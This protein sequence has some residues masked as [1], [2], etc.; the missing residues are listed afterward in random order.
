MCWE[1]SGCY[2][3]VTI[4]D[5]NLLL[6]GVDFLMTSMSTVEDFLVVVIR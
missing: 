2:K 4:T 5:E 6:D 1:R 3:P